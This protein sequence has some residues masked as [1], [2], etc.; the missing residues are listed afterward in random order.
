MIYLFAVYE[1]F[2]LHYHVLGLSVVLIN[3]RPCGVFSVSISR[4]ASTNSTNGVRLDLFKLIVQR[5]AL[6][7]FLRCYPFDGN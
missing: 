6:G 3:L 1:N 4:D 2:K 7:V 5:A